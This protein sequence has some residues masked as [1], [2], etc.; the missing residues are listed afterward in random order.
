MACSIN[1]SLGHVIS[2]KNRFFNSMGSRLANGHLVR[3]FIRA[4][5]A[6]LHDRT[7]SDDQVERTN[8]TQHFFTAILSGVY[9]AWNVSTS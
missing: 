1:Y 4:A 5:C 6:G 2:E 8:H 9:R 3:E 7:L